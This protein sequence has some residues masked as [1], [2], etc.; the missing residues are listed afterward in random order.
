M[1]EN[2]L[3]Q[4]KKEKETETR[5]EILLPEEDQDLLGNRLLS[6]HLFW[7]PVQEPE[8]QAVH[9]IRV[10]L[11]RQRRKQGMEAVRQVLQIAAQIETAAAVKEPDAIT[12]ANVLP[13]AVEDKKLFIIFY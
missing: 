11:Q 3:H 8:L 7:I 10:A 1:A 9:Q 12:T 4:P 5:Q 2:L 6:H 13:E